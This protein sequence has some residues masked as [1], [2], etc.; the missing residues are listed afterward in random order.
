[1]GG[2]TGN[3]SGGS[4]S[5]YPPSLYD[6]SV[7]SASGGRSSLRNTPTHNSF[8]H[9]R[10]EPKSDVMNPHASH[11]QQPRQP[12]RDYQL[13]HM[14]MDYSEYPQQRGIASMSDP[15]GTLLEQQQD[16]YLAQGEYANSD[17]GSPSRPYYESQQRIRNSPRLLQKNWQHQ[18]AKSHSTPSPLRRTLPPQHSPHHYQRERER[19]P[20]Y[21][22]Q[23]YVSRDRQSTYRESS[24]RTRG[25]DSYDEM[26]SSLRSNNDRSIDASLSSSTVSNLKSQLWDKD[27][28]L[29]V[30]APPSP[31]QT[32][33]PIPPPMEKPRRHSLHQ[34][35][36]KTGA[37]TASNNVPR[38]ARSLSP[39][40]DQQ[41]HL[42]PIIDQ[43][44]PKIPVAGGTVSDTSYNNR[45]HSKFFEAAL[46]AQ[47]RG[48][49]DDKALESEESQ[50]RVHRY[51]Q[52]YRPSSSRPFDEETMNHPPHEQNHRR[53]KS[54]PVSP[55]LPHTSTRSHP[56]QTNQKAAEFHRRNSSGMINNKHDHNSRRP[57]MMPPSPPPIS[58][59]PSRNYEQERRVDRGRSMEASQ[60]QGRSARRVRTPSPLILERIR[61]FDNDHHHESDPRSSHG[62]EQG[63]TKYD[64]SG[65]NELSAK[66]FRDR[67]NHDDKGKGKNNDI[68][69][70]FHRGGDKLINDE[71]VR[72]YSTGKK[73][74][75]SFRNDGGNQL[76]SENP[77]SRDRATSTL[78]TAGQ[79][80]GDSQSKYQHNPQEPL[81]DS[82]EDAGNERMASLVD[83]LSAINREN[84]ESAL[85]QIDSILRQ[86]SQ[87]YHT[88]T[89]EN[90][91]DAAGMEELGVQGHKNYTK[92]S[93][94]NTIQ[95]EDEDGIYQDE[96][97]DESSDVSSLT[98]PTFQQG[99]PRSHHSKTVD[100]T[101]I[102]ENDRYNLHNTIQSH[103]HGS[104]NFG[105]NSGSAFAPSTS[106][107]RR[108]R[109][110]HLQNYSNSTTPSPHEKSM[111]RS[112]WKRQQLKK[113]PPPT[114]IELKDDVLNPENGRPSPTDFRQQMLEKNKN[115]SRSKKNDEASDYRESAKVTK[116]LDKF[117][118][119]KQDLA[120]KI[121][122][123]DE[124]SNQLSP[125]RARND[126]NIQGRKISEKGTEASLSRPKPNSRRHPWDAKID[127]VRTKD[128]SMEGEV[129]IETEMASTGDPNLPDTRNHDT[130]TPSREGSDNLQKK[131]FENARS[132][133]VGRN[134][135]NPFEDR[136]FDTLDKDT[137][138]SPQFPDISFS[139]D[140]GD[141]NMMPKVNAS[142]AGIPQ[143]HPR[144]AYQSKHG[145][146]EADDDK[147]TDKERS[148]VAV[149]PSSFFP[150]VTE[151]LEPA[152]TNKPT[153]QVQ[154]S[155]NQDSDSNHLSENQTG[156]RR[157]ENI[158]CSLADV[159]R[160]N[161]PSRSGIAASRS[162]T[163]TLACKTVGNRESKPKEKKSGFLRAFME[164]K[165]KKSTGSG[166]AASAAA[167]SIGGLS[168][169]VESRG[170]KSASHVYSTSSSVSPQSMNIRIFPPPPGVLEANSDGRSNNSR[171]RAGNRNSSISR[172]RSKS[173]ERFRSSS[174][175]KKFN[176]VMQLYDNDEM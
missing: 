56:T 123:W 157:H 105:I 32:N 137:H 16:P 125:S 141:S 116:K 74:T 92:E 152:S 95:V 128:T 107:F 167:G 44:S 64:A 115:S 60:L 50:A 130:G 114:T 138:T 18:S 9:R 19:E 148:W 160:L 66:N 65:H 166:Y 51:Q 33:Q 171:G 24:F 41:H 161:I 49:D 79:I 8:G 163:Q 110:S 85:A 109:P 90:N 86:E 108:P 139:A 4:S 57:P 75:G 28:I 158:K 111:S 27:E 72:N 76:R 10:Q 54:I 25:E 53:N 45:F 156:G 7:S 96:D 136:D 17:V 81:R 169:S 159:D 15:G 20:N 94:L 131:H 143:F 71:N 82:A 68:A 162:F 77:R 121:R 35:P 3:H 34:K 112:D 113:F 38:Y 150:E 153:T 29:Q 101:Y 30:R 59:P 142:L 11:K 88:R 124:L 120:N 100:P 73:P 48:D 99:I 43:A 55:Q 151:S 173:S 144:N 61:S 91:R 13:S 103:N 22:S 26:N 140:D 87:T 67:I 127:V 149:P 23:Q 5:A 1:M 78:L 63:Y 104:G 42:P 133:I 118:A 6:T 36:L 129:G 172:A 145:E 39:R 117:V 84:P 170:F 2:S 132:K 135:H 119:D 97:D 168:N 126:G 155:N 147:S 174:M 37:N 165:K 176:R 14:N 12:N 102:P 146:N 93:S 122:S 52:P 134:A 46:V 62:H 175:A 70:G 106:S 58:S 40:R 69:T 164:K 98:N 80:Q 154:S 47:H 89:V 83:K 21:Y 31:Q